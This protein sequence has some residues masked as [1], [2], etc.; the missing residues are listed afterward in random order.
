MGEVKRY[1]PNYAAM[2]P[3]DDP[4]VEAEGGMFVMATDYATL[5][6]ENAKLRAELERREV[7]DALR[8][9]VNALLHQIDI[10][11]FVDS[12]GHSAKMLKP[13]HD[14]MRMLA[15]APSAPKA[16]DPVKVQTERWKAVCGDWQDTTLS[17]HGE[18]TGYIA[19]GI[20]EKAALA[21]I[22]AH[23]AALPA[24]I[25]AARKGEGE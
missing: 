11:D 12:Q 14:L 25:D 18:R 20:P 17:I 2:S 13:V 8:D 15:A 19:C 10:G 24:A 9:S 1:D 16:D 6:A 23:N 3:A 22:D 21:L 5:E 7:P 4:A